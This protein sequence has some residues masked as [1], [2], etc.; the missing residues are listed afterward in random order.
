MRKCITFK[1]KVIW[2]NERKS[3][4]NSTELLMRK[5]EELEYNLDF[6]RKLKKILYIDI[7]NNV[8]VFIYA[9]GSK[10]YLDVS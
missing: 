10:L 2:V 3:A 9:D 8:A 4:P 7:V 6:R 1:K 5:L